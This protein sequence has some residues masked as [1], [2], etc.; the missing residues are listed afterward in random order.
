MDAGAQVNPA[1]PG[2]QSRLGHPQTR[3]HEPAQPLPDRNRAAV[4][5]AQTNGC[6]PCFRPSRSI[7]VDASRV[8]VC[9]EGA[10]D[11]RERSTAE[12]GAVKRP[13]LARSLETASIKAAAIPRTVALPVA[14]PL[15][16][17][18]LR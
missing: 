4:P 14:V 11:S 12:L 16:R 2:R 1:A 3:S 15:T 7:T 10:F 5:S 8:S 18:A 13:V 6:A 9:V 17:C